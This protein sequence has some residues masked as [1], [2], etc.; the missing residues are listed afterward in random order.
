TC[1]GCHGVNMVN[2]GTSAYDLRRFPVDDPDRFF[3]SVS[4]GK[5]NM[6]AF[7]ESLNAEQIKL[8]WAYVGS[9]GGKEP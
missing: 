5:N 1:R 9:R 2:G 3:A 7:K 6:P 8:L 4:N